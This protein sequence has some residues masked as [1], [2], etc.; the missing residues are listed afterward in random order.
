MRKRVPMLVGV[1]VKVTTLLRSKAA[2][3]CAKS[4]V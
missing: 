2:S 1:K 3:S 4:Q